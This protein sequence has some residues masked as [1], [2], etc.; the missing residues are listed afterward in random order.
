MIFII[1]VVCFEKR[2]MYSYHPMSMSMSVFFSGTN[3]F[4]N[5][6]P[7]L[8]WKFHPQKNQPVAQQITWKKR[9]LM[10]FFWHVLLQIQ[11]QL[12]SSF[13]AAWLVCKGDLFNYTG[14][15]AVHCHRIQ[16][17]MLLDMNR[18]RRDGEKML[19]GSC[20]NVEVSISNKEPVRVL[21]SICH[22]VLC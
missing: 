21:T 13:C 4:S 20:S 17:I 16:K 5:V 10:W 18:Y 9:T 3:R 2:S 12:S 6:N 15:L 11:I 1:E 7:Q 22:W 19:R 8:S 14:K